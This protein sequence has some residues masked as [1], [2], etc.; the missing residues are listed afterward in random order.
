MN[1]NVDTLV[2]ILIIL[3]F[4]SGFFSSIETAFNCANKIR[5]KNMANNGNKKALLVIKLLEKSDEL[6]S[7][8]L[9]GNNIV[10]IAA[11]TIATL[12]FTKIY[13]DQGA[14]I[15]TI[16]MTLI[17]L[18][19]GEITPKSLAM[20]KPEKFCM[21]TARFTATLMLVFKPLTLIFSGWKYLVKKIFKF[22]EEEAMMQDELLTM[23]EEAENDGDLEAH[24]SDLICAAIEFNDLDVKDILTPRVDL[25]AVEIKSNLADVENIF[26]TNSFSRL[27]VYEHTIDNVVGFIHEKDFYAMYYRKEKNNLKSIVK[28]LIYTSKHVKIST[29]LRQLQKSNTHMAIVLDEYGGTV[30]VITLEDILEELVGDIWDEHDT[31][32]QLIKKVNDNTF[33]VEGEAEL[34]DLFELLD[35]EVDDDDFDFVTVGGFVVSEFDHIPQKGETFKF[36]DINF[37]VIKADNRRVEKVK[38]EILKK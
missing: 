16:V 23:V 3:I 25:V 11:A 30:G 35:I 18:V 37:T 1:S 21:F 19:F 4:L 36:S 24:E 28:T 5:L 8:V 2:F 27:P 15:S 26:R 20:E 12:I 17:V 29:L 7:T 32:K 6:L 33:I 9:I 34:D 31:V 13:G 22:E 14:T 10:N 38:V